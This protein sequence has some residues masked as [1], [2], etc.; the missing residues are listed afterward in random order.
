MH[1]VQL[2]LLLAVASGLL[3]IGEISKFQSLHNEYRKEYEVPP[4]SSVM[5]NIPYARKRYASLIFCIHILYSVIHPYEKFWGIEQ[6]S[7]LLL[8]F[9]VVSFIYTGLY[10][11]MRREKCVKIG[12]AYFHK[13]PCCVGKFAPKSGFRTNFSVYYLCQYTQGL[14][15]WKWHTCTFG[16][17]DS[18]SWRRHRSCIIK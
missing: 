8:A 1:S 2:I 9:K 12:C 4:K 7:A 14:K 6:I 15:I 5:N 16:I 10:L 13:T 18:C 3:L 17:K 11:R